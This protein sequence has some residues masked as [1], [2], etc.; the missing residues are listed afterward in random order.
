MARAH[1]D[2]NSLTCLMC[3]Y[4]QL[5]YTGDVSCVLCAD[6]VIEAQSSLEAARGRS[7]VPQGAGPRIYV[8]GIPN[9]VSETM[10]RNYF[11][12]WGK[13][14]CMLVQVETTLTRCMPA[15]QMCTHLLH[16]QWTRPT[17]LCR[18]RMYISQR[19]DH[20]EGGAPSVS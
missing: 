2:F 11:S 7:S 14:R 5:Q 9:A 12:N 19:R 4:V 13:V 10:V 6:M 3:Y 15:L 8:G 17:S 1:L 18:L 16:E 20:Q